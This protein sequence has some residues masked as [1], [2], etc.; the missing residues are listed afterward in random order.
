MTFKHYFVLALMGVF[1]LST[2]PALTAALDMT[3][4]FYFDKTLSGI[5]WTDKRG[6]FAVYSPL[7]GGMALILGSMAVS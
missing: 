5:D 6:L 1:G 7:F 2:L 3:W 4:W